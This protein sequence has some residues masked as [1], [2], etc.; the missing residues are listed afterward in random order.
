M[1][2]ELQE[3][4]HRVTD[5]ALA[6]AREMSPD[7]DI[8]VATPLRDARNALLESSTSASILVVGTRGRGPI[9]SL[10]LGSVSAAVADHAS[11]PVA[12]VR[13]TDRDIDERSPIVVATDGGPASTA[14][15]EFAFE[16]ASTE[17]RGIDIVECWSTQDTIMD[18]VG[19]SQNA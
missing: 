6:I 4:A 11:C 8:E 5:H 14:A 15:L 2:R 17:N 9:R 13:P 1:H 7:L 19:Y 18:T 3:G 10:L 16:L 12:V